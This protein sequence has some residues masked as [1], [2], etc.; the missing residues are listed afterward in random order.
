[1][2][3]KV[4]DKLLSIILGTISQSDRS[5]VKPMSEILIDTVDWGNY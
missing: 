1:M 3:G 2:A 5:R 4:V